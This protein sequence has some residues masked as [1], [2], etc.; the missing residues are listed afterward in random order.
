MRIDT[1]PSLP[2]TPTF[3]HPL[4]LLKDP[5][6]KARVILAALQINFFDIR[7]S[8]AVNFTSKFKIIIKSIN[9]GSQDL[10]KIRISMQN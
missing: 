7:S 10:L 1:L 9:F 4:S 6:F 2:T 5:N 3:P 8:E